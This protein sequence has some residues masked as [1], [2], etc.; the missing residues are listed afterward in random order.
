MAFS[1]LLLIT[2]FFCFFLFILLVSFKPQLISRNKII[3]ILSVLA[4]IFLAVFLFSG[5]QELN[6]DLGRIIRNTAPK[7]PEII[8]S[9]LFEKPIENCVTIIN[10]KDQVLPII[11][12]CIWI[13][14]NIC[15]KELGRILQTKKYE[16][17]IY[18]FADS[19]NSTRSFTEKP[20][21][22]NP[23]LL[24]DT[25]LKFQFTR[26]Q[27][28]IQTIFSGTDSTHIFICDLAN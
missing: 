16:A 21:W 28:H 6:R 9:V 15:P 17:S 1:S 25:I 12:C 23:Q 27:N 5:K 8:Y 4:L 11:D 22:W 24:G 3:I 10:L 20:A 19:L 14:I 26:D 18:N 7:S 13:E 2:I